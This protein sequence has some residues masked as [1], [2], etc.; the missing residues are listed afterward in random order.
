M[1]VASRGKHIRAEPISALYANNK[2]HHVGRFPRLEDQL[3]AFSPSGYMGEDSPDHAD[4]MIHAATYL[5]TN[6][7]GTAIIEYYR[8]EVELLEQNTSYKFPAI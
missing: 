5:M 4:A 3:C 8:R 7:D 6:A 1:V 2:I